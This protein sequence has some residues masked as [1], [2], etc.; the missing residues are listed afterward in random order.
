[1]SSIVL[2]TTTF[3]TLNN[4]PDL[5]QMGQFISHSSL[6]RMFICTRISFSYTNENLAFPWACWNW[7]AKT[8]PCYCYV[9]VCSALSLL[10]KIV[11]SSLKWSTKFFALKV[12]GVL[13][14]IFPDSY[15]VILTMNP[16]LNK[17][18]IVSSVSGAC[19]F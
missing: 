13:Y 17:F 16:W 15:F 14:S 5:L 1:M 10:Y 4:P 6:L 18:T 2:S 19:Y 9:V 3:L 11:I 8:V 7:Q 12:S